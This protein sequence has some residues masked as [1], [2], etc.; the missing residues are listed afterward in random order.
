MGQIVGLRPAGLPGTT[1]TISG[2][3]SP[4]F[5]TTTVSPMRISLLGD[6]ILIVWGG[7]GDGGPRQTHRLQL[8]LGGQ[9]A[10]AAHLHHDIPQH[11][12]L[13]L[14]GYL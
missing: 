13:L 10:G 3:I 8:R 11:R 6:V 4:A 9:H 2:M 1:E 5:C 7:E 14:R 12:L